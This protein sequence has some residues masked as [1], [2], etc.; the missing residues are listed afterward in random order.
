[1]QKD[2]EEITLTCDERWTCTKTK[3]VKNRDE[4]AALN[5][6]EGTPTHTYTHG[7]G[8]LRLRRYAAGPEKQELTLGH[9]NGHE[10][11][12]Y[13]HLSPEREPFKL[14]LMIHLSIRQFV[15][16]LRGYIS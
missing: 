5:P 11:E 12:T 4:A 6:D 16:R 10:P 1:M 13:S 9:L 14:L 7:G 3:R 2:R 15:S 8:R